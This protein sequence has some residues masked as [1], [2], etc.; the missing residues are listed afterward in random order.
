MLIVHET[1]WL[2]RKLIV[3][4]DFNHKSINH[5]AALIK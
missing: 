2:E 5:I 4:A 1:L 3:S